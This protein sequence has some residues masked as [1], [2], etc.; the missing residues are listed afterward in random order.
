MEIAESYGYT[1]LYLSLCIFLLY[2]VFML[3]ALPLRADKPLQIT[4]PSV[5]E[6]LLE[7]MVRHIC[8]SRA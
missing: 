4:A 8:T 1:P 3:P 2:I 7:R 5:E 6:Q